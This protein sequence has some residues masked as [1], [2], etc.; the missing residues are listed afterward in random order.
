MGVIN[1]DINFQ[2]TGVFDM[3]ND[4]TLFTRVVPSGK[5]VVYY[6]AYDGEGNRLGP[7]T[8]GQ[9]NK[10]AARNYCNKLNRQGALLPGP[11]EIPTFAEYAAGFWDWENSPYLKDRK[12]RRKLTE[13][14][15]D[16]NKKVV[17]HTLIPYFGEMKLDTISG[18]VIDQWLDYMIAEKYENSTTNGYFGT[19]M[20]MMKWAVRKRII[21][22]DPFLDVQRLMNEQK[23]K[24]LITH[25]EF[26]M[27]FVDDWKRVWDNDALLCTAN[28]LAA[29]TGM[30]VSEVL[31]LKG[32]DIFDDHIFVA[33]QYDRKR[34]DRETKTKTKDNIPLTGELIRD[35]RKLMKVNGNGYLFSLTGGDKPV[36]VRHIYNGLIRALKRMGLADGDIKERGLNVHAWRHFCNTEMLNAGIPIKKVQAVTRHK[37]E[38]MTDRY[39]HFNPL[40]FVEVTNLQAELLK[41]KTAKPEVRIS[42]T[43]A[44]ERPALSLVKMPEPDKTVRRKQAS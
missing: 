39:T 8:T 22:R 6:Y 28:K 43:A 31:G 26:K 12:K 42:N 11:V 36:T 20:T 29:L 24:Q 27:M 33:V 1:Y 9:A 5:T 38:R 13:G 2:K 32:E 3:H 15:A 25:D 17:D 35:L 14:Y 37:S 23:E 10:T 19:L 30:R 40:E 7:W 16:K 4:F 44:D 41:K 34:G 18:E 21:V